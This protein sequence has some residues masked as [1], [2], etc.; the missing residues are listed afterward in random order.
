MGAHHQSRSVAFSGAHRII[1]GLSLGSLWSKPPRI[2]RAYHCRLSPL[3]WA[4]RFSPF[5]ATF[6]NRSR[7][8]PH[9]LIRDG[10]PRRIR[11]RCAA[12]LEARAL[13]ASRT[14]KRAKRDAEPAKALRVPLSA[15]VPLKLP[16]LAQ[17]V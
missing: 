16:R 13:A 6:I 7:K 14:S 8:G 10:A 5:L 4:A 12:A 3:N 15:T 1:A 9:Q 2:G 11:R 17:R